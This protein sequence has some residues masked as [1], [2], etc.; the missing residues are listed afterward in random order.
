M[1]EGGF[2]RGGVWHSV[3][4][5]ER[6]DPA[7][8]LILVDVQRAFLTGADAVPA[9][10]ALL[11][12]LAGLLDSARSAGA[13][14]VH[15]RNDGE[16]GAADEPGIPG[17]ELALPVREGPDEHVMAKAD[18]DGFTGTGLGALLERRGVG[19]VVVAGVLSEM[20]VSATAFG[21]LERGL[22][23]VLPHDAHGTYGLDD[24][25]AEVVARVAEHA[26]GSDP[27]LL[28]TAAAVRF[29]RPG[30]GADGASS[31]S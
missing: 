21:A 3:P 15:L 17:W 31:D 25:P 12:V 27:E 4:R 1:S 28:R 13:V 2:V 30:G 22:A 29:V 19:R 24:L 26:L 18:D 8:A 14:V 6:A 11:P 20:C 9:A 16:P 7:D 5:R 23:V 10:P